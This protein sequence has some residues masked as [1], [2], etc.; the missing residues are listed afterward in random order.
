MRPQKREAPMKRIDVHTHIVPKELPDFKKKFGYGGFIQVQHKDSC[1]A[2][3][4]RDDGTFF[5]DICSNSWD[6][7]VRMSECSKHNVVM[8][9]L[10][11]VPIFFTYWAKPH[12]ALEVGKYLNDHIAAIANEKPLRFQGLGTVPLQDTDLAIKEL[13]RCMRNGLRGV[14]IGTHV[15]GYNL[16]HPK[17]FPFFEAC[18]DLGASVFVHPWDMLGQERMQDYWLAWLVGMPTETSLAICHLIFSGVLHKLPDLRIA[19][20]HGGGSFPG[21]I[22]R[23]EKGFLARPD[24]CAKDNAINPRDYLGRFFIDSIVHDKSMFRHLINLVG[25]DKVLL[26]SDYPFPL[27]EEVPGTLIESLDLGDEIKSKI[28]IKNALNWLGLKSDFLEKR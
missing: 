8:Q 27:G 17:L 7:N 22:G 2:T 9:V 14:E 1:N 24:L 20:A 18:Q 19:F 10:S 28:Y 16:G 15:N 26:G 5:R 25:E 23:I 12:D 3:M 11:T 4:I 21:T 6:E 13:E